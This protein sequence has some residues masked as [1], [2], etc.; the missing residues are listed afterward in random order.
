MLMHFPRFEGAMNMGAGKRRKFNKG[1]KYAGWV[2][3]AVYCTN[4]I[5]YNGFAAEQ[6]MLIFID[7]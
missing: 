3:S 5:S 6:L 4:Y 2:A 7:P 1:I